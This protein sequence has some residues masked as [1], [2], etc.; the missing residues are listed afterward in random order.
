[1]TV[2]IQ[3]EEFDIAAEVA[4]LRAGGANVG[5]IVTFTG[6]C[7]G[8]DDGRRLATLT[9]ETYAEMAAQEIGRI[10]DEAK[11]RWPLYDALV[12]HRYGCMRPGDD[13]VLVVTTS[14]HREAAFCAA[15]FLMDYL[16]TRAPFWKSEE[17]IAG[18]HS[19]VA[20]KDS[21]DTAAARW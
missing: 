9:L 16:K 21:D 1:M 15:A 2:R 13:I 12:I 6:I 5:A 11:E 7:R 20:A 19:W 8:E 18:E 3:T 10:V 4:R 14:A 17:T